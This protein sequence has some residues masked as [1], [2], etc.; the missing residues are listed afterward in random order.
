MASVIVINKISDLTFETILGR[1]VATEAGYVNDPNDSGG[2]TNH[3]V[4]KATAG[5]FAADLKRLYNWD[6]TMR[7]LSQ[8][9]ALYVFRKG[10]W[11]RLACDDLLKISPLLADRVFDFGIN[12]GRAASALALQQSVNA[13]NR[14]GKDYPDVT[15]DSKLGADGETIRAIQA[16]V[17]KRGNA[18]VGSLLT[19][20]IGENSH[21]YVSISR[22][23]PK[24]EE[25][26]NGWSTRV[27]EAT[28]LYHQL[29]GRK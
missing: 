17:A 12:A 20:V 29:I 6:G 22:S 28:N 3:G 24:N 18:G 1:C 21:F 27:F 25:F 10:W 9:M 7:N 23:K 19:L 8:E 14:Q 15:E 2:E 26:M 13:L 5:D 16:L 11:E 4:T